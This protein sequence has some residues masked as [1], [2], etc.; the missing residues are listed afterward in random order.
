MKALYEQVYSAIKKDILSGK[1]KIGDRVPSEKELS[2]Q[3]KVSRITSKRALESLEK[4][5]I[6]YRQ[7][8][9]GTFV[10]EKW[11]DALLATKKQKKP[12]IGLILT[13]FDDTYGSKI[14]SSI[15]Y[16]TSETAFVILKRS[17]GSPEKEESI[18]KELLSIEVDGIIIYPAQA[19][20]YS[21]EILK[22]VVDKFPFVLIDRSFKGVA[23]SSVSTDNVEAA[24]K[25]V[26]YLFK[27]GHKNI[28]VISPNEM[29]TTTLQDRFSGIVEAYAEKEL[30]VNKNLWCTNINSTLAEPKSTQEEDIKEIEQYI[31]NNP[32]LTAL[33]AFEYNIARLVHQAVN[34]L[35]L[36]VPKDISIICFDEPALNIESWKFT[37]LVQNE[38]EIGELAI[39]YLMD[40]INGDD[41]IKQKKLSASL[42]V[43]DS[44]ASVFEKMDKNPAARRE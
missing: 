8:G 6:V 3:F 5:G 23:A 41:T 13:N 21:S 32:S 40:M 22:M 39:T 24:K 2:D 16:A 20:H 29:G 30:I 7:K 17:F 38:E 14:I 25:G 26:E 4:D 34:N 35:G 15:E 18:L 19:E 9:K 10:S 36:H 11:E 28:G 37:R 33:F 27:L 43:G 1:Y 12:L 31:T 42:I 44:T